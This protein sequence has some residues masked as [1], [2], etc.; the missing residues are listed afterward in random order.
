MNMKRNKLP[1][2]AYKLA[3]KMAD[4]IN[5]AAAYSKD[6]GIRPADQLLDALCITGFE[7]EN[8][9]PGFWGDRGSTVFNLVHFIRDT[10]TKYENNECDDAYLVTKCAPHV[11]DILMDIA[12]EL[13]LKSDETP[14]EMQ[15]IH[16]LFIHKYDHKPEPD[17]KTKEAED[18]KSVR[19][20][21]TLTRIIVMQTQMDNMLQN[22]ESDIIKAFFGE[23]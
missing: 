23:A 21:Q 11:V 13:V 4:R 18:E 16:E 6:Y 9:R 10:C 15:P 7:L 20:Q 14:F 19:R 5:N 3:R 17:K 22:L 12:K 8:S 1:M 2:K